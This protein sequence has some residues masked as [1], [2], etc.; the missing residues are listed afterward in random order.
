MPLREEFVKQGQFLFRW[1]SYV[2]L[3]TL[4][5]FAIGV[6][7]HKPI[8]ANHL[9]SQ[10][11]EF[12]CFFV[13]LI[14]LGIRIATIGFVPKGTSGRN[15]KKQVADVLN[16][17]GMYSM[18]RHPL[19]LGNF[20]MWLG[21]AMWLIPHW[22]AFAIILFYLIYYERIMFAEEEYLRDKFGDEYVT[23]DS[24]RS[25]LIPTK[26][27]WERPEL[28]FSFRHIL[29]REHD[30]FF[31][32]IVTYFIMDTATDLRW[33][34]R[35]FADYVWLWVLVVGTV[36]YGILKYLKKY[37]NVLRVEGR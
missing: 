25:P 5:L 37:T 28:C 15:T 11:Y 23:W 10:I 1:R 2:P 27:R 17:K 19:Y 12:I 36:I 29:K 34:H 18:L 13:S 8:I 24:K 26:F 30:G 21:V 9:W 14:G 33:M 31:G 16:T 6:W 3:V 35:F 20:I 7:Y 22:T 4:P 32:I